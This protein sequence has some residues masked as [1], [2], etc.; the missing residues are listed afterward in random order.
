M[1]L[2]HDLRRRIGDVVHGFR[3]FRG[4]VDGIID[5]AVSGWV[6]PTKPGTGKLRVGLFSSQGLVAETTATL[7]RGDLAAAGIGDGSHGFAF[8]L[9]EIRRSVASAAGAAMTVRVLG[10]KTGVLGRVK[11]PGIADEAKPP[12]SAHSS[13]SLQQALHG[14]I[15]RLITAAR[16]EAEAPAARPEAPVLGAHAA[17]FDTRDHILGGHDL[18]APL[19]GY[20]DYTRYRFK[21]DQMFDIHANPEEASHFLT[22]YLGG[23]ST[24]R[25]GRRVPMS[26]EMLDY[27]NAPMRIPGQ[28]FSLSRA[29]WS[30]LQNVPPIIGAMDFSNPDWVD[31]VVYWW[32]INQARALNVEDCLVPE[33][34]VRRLARVVQEDREMRLPLSVFM[35]RFAAENAAL[36]G[37]DLAQVEDRRRLGLALLSMAI[38]RPDY[39]RFI[40]AE[41]RDSLL[42]PLG[43]ERVDTAFSKFVEGITHGAVTGLSAARFGRILHRRGFDLERLGFRSFTAEG[44]RVEAAMLPAV[45]GTEKV[46]VQII[47]PFEKASGLGQASRLSAAALAESGFSMNAV[48]FDL[49]NPAPE[50][51]S[52][53]TALSEYRPA[54]VNLLHLNAESIPLAYAYQPD[55]FSGAYNIGYFF[56][57]LD[58]PAASHYLA[59]DMLDEIWVSTEYGV[60]IY[61]PAADI[62]VFNV[63][64][65]V[66]DIPEIDRNAARSF[67]CDRFGFENE[68]FVF[69]TVFDSFSFVQR[70]NPVGTLKAFLAAFPEGDENVRLVIKTQNRTKVT[71]PAQVK[72]WAEVDALISADERINVVDETFTYPDLLRLKTGCDAFVSLHKSEGWGF[73]M[74]EAMNLRLPVICTA[75]S[76]NMEFCSDETAWLVDYDEVE[77]GPDEYIFVRPGQKWAEPDVAHAAQQMRAVWQDAPMRASRSEAAWRNVRER[78][79]ATAIGRRYAARLEDILMEEHARA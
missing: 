14:D 72:I 17:L 74:I 64:M 44:H 41:T 47:G 60:S 61:R 70:K 6:A 16:A 26:R 38:S 52:T 57:E 27:L 39:L 13:G 37:L 73:G 4:H 31:W 30:S 35:R 68:P 55:V 19:T 63:G 62:P 43:S 75:Y 24:L 33:P 10:P 46:D 66:E 32:S 79:S 48:D 59:L 20:A 2:Q 3:G 65:C 29:T 15:Q 77:L 76:G 23:Y 25:Q 1:P 28:R 5:G 54:R 40:P 67:V 56:W 69:L 78:F 9:D 58:T 8:P 18:P 11:L 50:G 21:L 22:W 34:Y 36:S 12:H 7:L 51:F 45:T 42:G 49:D 71:D 53:K